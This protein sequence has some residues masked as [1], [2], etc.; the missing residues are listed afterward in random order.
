MPAGPGSSPLP[1]FG[2]REIRSSCAFMLISRRRRPSLSAISS[3]GYRSAKCRSLATSPSVQGL[4]RTIGTS[5]SFLQLTRF[6]G[7]VS[8]GT[9]T[10]PRSS[11]GKKKTGA[12]VRGAP[13]L[14]R[15]S[16]LACRTGLGVFPNGRCP[17]SSSA[18]SVASRTW[19]YRTRV[20]TVFRS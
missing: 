7:R 17:C 14:R 2:L 20:K 6:G 19:K 11:S 12:I 18:S 4:Y 3:A 16:G 9:G 13:Y 8:G 10:A 5:P 1:N 15:D